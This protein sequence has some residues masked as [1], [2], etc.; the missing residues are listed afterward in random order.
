MRRWTRSKQPTRQQ[1][2]SMLSRLEREQR[3]ESVVLTLQQRREL[4]RVVAQ[5]LLHAARAM[6][7]GS[8]ERNDE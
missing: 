4:A 3:G 7:E 5:L 1:Q 2:L 8:E 6:A